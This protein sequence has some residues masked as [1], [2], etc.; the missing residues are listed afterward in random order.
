MKQLPFARKLWAV[1][2]HSLRPQLFV[3]IQIHHS[4]NKKY[5][6]IWLQILVSTVI[7]YRFKVVE[8]VPSALPLSETTMGD[9]LVVHWLGFHAFTAKGPGSIPGQG[10]KILKASKVTKKQ[11]NKKTPHNYK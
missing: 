9:S 4:I 6:G 11:T 5:L 7:G 8:I 1:I 10:T 2:F 3:T